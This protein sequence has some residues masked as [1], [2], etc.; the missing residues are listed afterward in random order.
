MARAR[1]RGPVFWRWAIAGMLAAVLGLFALVAFNR[2][3]A[4]DMVTACR[5]DHRDPAHTILLIDQSDPFNTNDLGWVSEFMDE[6]AR[7]LPK[8]GRLTVLTPNAAAPYDLIEVYSHCSPGSAEKANPVTQNPRM[9]EDAWRENFYA[10]LK[11]S[12]EIVLTEKSQNAS[13]L[14]EAIYSIGDRADFTADTQIRRLLIISDLMQHSEAFSFY[15][16][17][18]DFEAF[19][20]TRLAEDIPDLSHVSVTARI[21][22]RE[23]YDLPLSDVKYFWSQYFTRTGADYASVN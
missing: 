12:I 13:P 15:R 10:P 14:A 3:P 18:A 21:V 8:Y 4:L 23:I 9:I 7:L 5:A 22:P 11:A 1:E 17:G 20:S 6:E 19:S 16:T 2:P